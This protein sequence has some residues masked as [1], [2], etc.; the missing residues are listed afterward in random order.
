M[1]D[2]DV[3]YRT[4]RFRN[5]ARFMYMLSINDP[6]TS[7]EVEG[8]Q[9]SARFTGVRADPLNQRSPGYVSLPNAPSEKWSEKRP[10]TAHGEIRRYSRASA[11]MSGERVIDVYATP[12]F[13]RG[14]GLTP[15]LILFDGDESRDML[16]VP[17]ILDNLYADHRIGEM[18]AVFLVQPYE[19]RET[20]LECSQ[21]TNL[22]LVNELLPWLREEYE[23]RTEPGSTVAA[24]AS[25]GG[26]AATYAGLR[27]PE[28]IGK[29]L[30]QSGSFWWG[31]TDSQPEWLTA[32]V[33][34]SQRVK[35]DFYLDVG[36]METNGE[37]L[38]QLETNRQFKDA[39]E[40]KGYRV[41]YREYNGIHGFP[42]W[43]AGLRGRLGGACSPT[44]QRALVYRHGAQRCARLP[45]RLAL[46]TRRGRKRNF[47]T[48][49]AS[50][51][52]GFPLHAPPATTRPA[53]L[54]VT[55]VS[56]AA[57]VACA[58]ASAG[59]HRNRECPH[60]QRHVGPAVGCVER[61]GAG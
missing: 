47:D 45:S 40:R 51:R 59:R 17:I 14:R 50:D 48:W 16:R 26:L 61:S 28:A 11:A 21:N 35:V 41:I 5:D 46:A 18:L 44:E 55:C 39:L 53:D 54:G 10:E 34:S 60:L 19:H 42:C 37:K 1:A 22:Y 33:R 38:S 9:R 4:Y 2:T 12:G 7:W 20:D 13:K 23:I 31:K 43:R 15:V 49:P 29:V 30:S 58:G 24:G 56:A 52:D 32:E 36:L 25:L 3:W 6:L 27:H 57:R 8:P